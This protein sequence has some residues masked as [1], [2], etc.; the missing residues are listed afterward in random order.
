MK[1]NVSNASHR[2]WQKLG[3][4]LLPI[5]LCASGVAQNSPPCAAPPTGNVGWWPFDSDTHDE[6]SGTSGVSI[7]SPIFTNGLV[8]Q[9]IFLNGAGAAVRIPATTA[10]NLGASDGLSMEAWINVPN[11]SQ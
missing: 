6:V 8:G 9:A 1:T 2:W 4:C 11:F 5:L 3:A 7:G 10:I